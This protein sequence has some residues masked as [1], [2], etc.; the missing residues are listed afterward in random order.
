MGAIRADPPPGAHRGG[1]YSRVGAAASPCEG[2]PPSALTRVAAT[3]AQEDTTQA[4][5]RGHRHGSL[6][7]TGA[8][9]NL[10]KEPEEAKRVKVWRREWMRLE[11][12]HG[13]VYPCGEKR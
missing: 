7:I 1:L 10:T 11:W 9:E 2:P 4:S 13:C 5:S 6:A 8:A 3:R 12:N